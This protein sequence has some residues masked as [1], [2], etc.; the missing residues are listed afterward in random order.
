MSISY[1]YAAV[2]EAPVYESVVSRK[3]KKIINRILSG[4]Y[5]QLGPEDG[6][7]VKV[8]TAGPDGWM[9]KADLTDNMY[10]KV[11][12]LDVGQGDGILIEA[13]G[14]NEANR[15][16]ILIDSGPDDNMFRYLTKWQ[17]SYLLKAKEKVKID[18]VFVSHFDTDHY[19]GLTKILEHPLFTFGNIYHP[20][21]LKFAVS[22]NLYDTDL[23]NLKEENGNQYLTTIFN[24]LLNT[25]NLSPFNSDISRFIKALK[26][27]YDE[28]RIAGQIARIKAGN[29]LINTQIEGKIFQVEVLAPI[30]ENASGNDAFIYWR[31]EGKTINGHSL[32]LKIT[33]GNRTFL[34][35]GDHNKDSENYL[36]GKY[37]ANSPFEVD[38]AKSCHHGSSDF[39]IDFMKLINPYATII[40]SGDNESYAHPRADAI[41][42]A[43]KY[44]KGARPL[45]FS[46][47][48]A[49]SVDLRTK[50]ILYGLI[51]C[52]CN[53]SDI[54]ISQMKER[55]NSGD[56]WDSYNI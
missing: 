26:K 4:T 23:G 12:V 52:R 31:E 53:G 45:V 2:N 19:K 1:K 21:I 18:H 55:Q 11:V 36:I 14:L 8:V 27:A 44:S 25:N 3:G 30:E 49:R 56:L 41:G 43:G 33:F 6:D 5:V 51:N 16:R 38:V 9:K 34:F 29:L 17:Y 42:C 48:L 13:G 32:I 24:D 20:G 50:K 22:Q 39:T 37:K 28:G 15:L 10:F 40:S 35:G 46:T 7:F 47:E 54:Y